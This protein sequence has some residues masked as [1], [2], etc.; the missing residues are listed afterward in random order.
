MLRLS[1]LALSQIPRKILSQLTKSLSDM[2]IAKK[3]E[4]INGFV[5]VCRE[6]DHFANVLIV[7][8]KNAASSLAGMV[9]KETRKNL[10]GWNSCARDKKKLSIPAT[11]STVCQENQ[12]KNLRRNLFRQQEMNII[13]PFVS[14]LDK[15]ID[16]GMKRWLKI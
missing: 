1:G 15:M 4:K 10:A 2:Q 9:V 8:I 6:I 14:F 12:K 7:F 5:D 3:I 11:S 16:Y 13:R